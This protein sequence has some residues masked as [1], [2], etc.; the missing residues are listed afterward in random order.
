MFSL[1]T[2]GDLFD[3]IQAPIRWQIIDVCYQLKVFDLLRSEIT[4]PEVAENL[5]MDPV[6]TELLLDALVSLDVAAKSSGKYHISLDIAPWL[7]SDSPQCL[8]P[9]MKAMK[10]I[11]H[12]N[13]MDLLKEKTASPAIDMSDA[14]FW[15]NSAES[16]RAY[17][18][19]FAAQELLSFLQ[20]LP[21][22]SSAKRF[23]EIGA[24]SGILAQ[25]IRKKHPEKQITVLDLPPMAERIEKSLADLSS[26]TVLPGDYNALEIPPPQDIIC[27]SMTLYFAND[28]V[29]VLERLKQSLSRNGVFFSFHEGLEKE[30]TKPENHVIGRLIPA[31]K[32]QNSSF[33]K[34]D[35]STA[36]LKAGFKTVDSRSVICS[37]GPMMIDIGRI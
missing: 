10:T 13:L 34:G 32:G 20:E 15:D 3:L 17:H 35:I 36:L 23:M 5:V 4:A 30:R 6:K 16:L 2:P 21:E 18:E 27:G 11:R 14:R 19:G 25:M 26:I 1:K 24:G 31:L 9:L 29:S 37:T 33:N 22:W 7:L 12:G 8:H 28:L